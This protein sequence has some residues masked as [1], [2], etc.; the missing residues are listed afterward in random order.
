MDI[1]DPI[2]YLSAIDAV[3]YLITVRART[4]LFDFCG[5]IFTDLFINIS[6]NNKY[7]SYICV[8]IVSYSQV[9]CIFFIIQATFFSG[10]VIFIQFLVL[11]ISCSYTHNLLF[12]ELHGKSRLPVS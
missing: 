4:A 9:F 7:N 5:L 3:H 12:Y 1:S 10:R 11:K 8:F 6:R 2:Q